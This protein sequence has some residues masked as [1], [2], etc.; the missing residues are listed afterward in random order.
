MRCWHQFSSLKRI[1]VVAQYQSFGDK[2]QRNVITTDCS[3]SVNLTT[4]LSLYFKPRLSV[5]LR[6]EVFKIFSFNSNLNANNRQFSQYWPI[7]ILDHW[8]SPSRSADRDINSKKNR[9]AYM[10][11]ELC[12]QILD[13]TGLE[14]ERASTIK[15]QNCTH[16][17]NSTKLGMVIDYIL[18]IIDTGFQR[19]GPGLYAFSI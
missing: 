15:A 14:R 16:P 9:L 8:Y 5:L 4:N 1:E 13:S 10:N 6:S 19:S 11:R 3:K 2:T 7:S 12:G 18:N 17:Y